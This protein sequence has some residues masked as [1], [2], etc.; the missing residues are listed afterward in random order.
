MEADRP[1]DTLRLDARFAVMT[2]WL[3]GWIRAALLRKQDPAL[4]AEAGDY[5][6]RRLAQA[7]AGELTA[8]V[9]HADLRRCRARRRSRARRPPG[10]VVVPTRAAA[11]R[12]VHVAAAGRRP[13]P[14]GLAARRRPFVDGLRAVDA[15]ALGPPR[16]ALAAL[17]TVCCAWRWKVV[18]GG[19]GVSCRW[20]RGGPGVL[21]LDF[22]NL[23]LPGGVVG[24]P[25]GSPGVARVVWE[26]TAG[27]VLQIVLTVAVLLAAV[28]RAAGGDAALVAVALLVAASSSRWRSAGDRRCARCGRGRSSR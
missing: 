23:T 8:T 22:L 14:P 24:R 4:A 21:P 18:A 12:A 11:T 19:L 20:A 27:Q 9:D 3:G 2:E 17:T 6:E 1:A 16:T 7:A 15:G 26:R 28:A 5:R 13:R 25:P 10:A